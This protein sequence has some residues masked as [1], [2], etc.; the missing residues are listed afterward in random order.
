MPCN[1]PV[2]TT[3]ARCEDE[4]QSRRNTNCGLVALVGGKSVSEDRNAGVEVG[5]ITRKSP[6]ERLIGQPDGPT[7]SPSLTPDLSGRVKAQV[8]AIESKSEATP[9]TPSGISRAS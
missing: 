7:W 9:D 3:G 2:A 8:D 6:S 5:R 1:L 4:N